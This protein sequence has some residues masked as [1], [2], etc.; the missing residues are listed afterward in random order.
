VQETSTPN[1]PKPPVKC[2]IKK[3][4]ACDDS[5]LEEAFTILKQS[6]SSH[7]QQ[8]LSGSGIFGQHVASKLDTY[9]PKTRAFV[10]HS[11]NNILFEADI[12]RF[13]NYFQNFNQPPLYYQNPATSQHFN[14]PAF[15][16]NQGIPQHVNLPSY[17]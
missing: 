14:Q 9:T 11:I 3:Y 1:V 13:E 4:S 8:P 2:P 12:D 6:A 16:Q 17:C 7:Q 5:R 10:E 15:Y